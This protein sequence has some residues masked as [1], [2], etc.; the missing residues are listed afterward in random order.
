MARLRAGGRCRGRVR[1]CAPRRGERVHGAESMG[2]RTAGARAEQG[3]G[4]GT[5]AGS[6]LGGARGGELHGSQCREE[7]GRRE[8]EGK[9]KEKREMEKEKK[10]KGKQEKKQARAIGIRGSRCDSVGHAQCRVRA[11]TRPQ[12]KDRGRESDVRNGERD[13]GKRTRVLRVF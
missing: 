5:W 4:A 9:K 10:R 7:G 3:Q 13:S 2:E 1:L 12:Q 8:G 11:R 6:G